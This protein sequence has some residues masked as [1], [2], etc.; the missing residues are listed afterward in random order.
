MRRGDFKEV[1]FAIMLLVKPNIG[2][3]VG[4][5][6]KDKIYVTM[7]AGVFGRAG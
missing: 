4:G 3:G 2:G 1:S 7:L 6:S 5:G